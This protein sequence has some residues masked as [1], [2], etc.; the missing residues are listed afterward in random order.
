MLI[1]LD[2]DVI[3]DVLLAREPWLD[4]AAAL[5]RAH[6]EGR[7]RASIAATTVTNIFYIVRRS[8][9]LERARA[10]VRICL[11]TFE[12]IPVDR[13]ALEAAATMSGGD[14]EDNVQ[15]ACALH[16]GLDLIVTRNIPDFVGGPVAALTP[17]QALTRLGSTA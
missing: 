9:G 8:A 13:P 4:E 14:F 1:L 16:A 12:V 15:I 5:W 17:T 2:T 7:I 6:E 3:L 11:D 10:A